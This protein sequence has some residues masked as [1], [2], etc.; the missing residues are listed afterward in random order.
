MKKTKIYVIAPLVFLIA[1]GAYYWNFSS[2]YEAQQAAVVAHERQ[3]RLD[4]LKAEAEVR[5]H[6]IHDAIEA[7]KVRKAERAAREEN[8][9]QQKDNM[10]NAKLESEKAIEESEK[11]SRQAEKL[12]KDVAAAKEEIVKLE[13]DQKKS[14]EEIE[15][16]KRYT[17]AAV[18]NQS[19]L[20]AVMTKIEDADAAAAKAAALAAAAAAKK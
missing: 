10:Q 8:E 17:A 11:L 18:S 1:F 7:Q 2:K 16:L 20:A 5:E 15:F 9:R 3:R 4:K 14:L 6:A 13:T 12:T 19:K